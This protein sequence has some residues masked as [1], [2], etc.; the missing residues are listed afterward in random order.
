MMRVLAVVIWPFFAHIVCGDDLPSFRR[1]LAVAAK[2]VTK[3]GRPLPGS[4]LKRVIAFNT[5]KS[6]TARQRGQ[7]LKSLIESRFS[8]AAVIRKVDFSKLDA[9]KQ[10][11]VLQSLREK[12]KSTS[13][14]K[15]YTSKIYQN[16]ESLFSADLSQIRLQQA[17][18]AGV[19][20]HEANLSGAKLSK[21]S[22]VEAKLARCV[23]NRAMLDQC[24]L[25]KADLSRASLFQANLKNADLRGARLS[26]ANLLEADLSGAFVDTADWLESCGAKLDK[27]KW[28]VKDGRVCRATGEQ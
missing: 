27:N 7:L 4:L 17:Q 20:L 21:A 6:T 16:G 8:L 14:R 28:R 2:A 15:A 10:K 11:L 22:L 26:K 18:L 13:F 9:R 24:N 19:D 5:A 12:L 25:S 3:P 23:L 1:D